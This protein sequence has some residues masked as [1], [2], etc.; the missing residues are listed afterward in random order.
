[1]KKPL[2]RLR[3]AIEGVGRRVSA[4]VLQEKQTKTFKGSKREKQNRSTLTGDLL[5]RAGSE[6]KNHGRNFSQSCYSAEIKDST[7]NTL[8]RPN[9]HFA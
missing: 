8:L 6:L 1:M 2:Q 9:P 3:A 7:S 4:G 5:Q